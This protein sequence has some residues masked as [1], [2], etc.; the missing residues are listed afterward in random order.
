MTPDGCPAAEHTGRVVQ[1]V[2][3]AALAQ[4]APVE[5]QLARWHAAEWE[6]LYDPAVW[7]RD[8]A[9]AELRAMGPVGLPRTLVARDGTE[10]VG[11]VSLVVTDDLPGWDGLGPWLASLFVAPPWIPGGY[12][13]G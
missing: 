9:L 11:S 8:I 7:D 10:L 3:L 1:I 5:E 4:R 6:H 2:D 12:E 13:T